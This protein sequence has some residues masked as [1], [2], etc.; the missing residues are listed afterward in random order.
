MPLPNLF[1][2]PPLNLPTSFTKI[3]HVIAWW[4]QLLI[5]EDDGCTLTFAKVTKGEFPCRPFVHYILDNN[6]SEVFACS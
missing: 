6:G 5:M 3:E 4:I 1:K 2:L